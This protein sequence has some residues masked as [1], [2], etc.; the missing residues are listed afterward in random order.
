MALCIRHLELV[1]RHESIF[2]FCMDLVELGEEFY[3]PRLTVEAVARLETECVALVDACTVRRDTVPDAR[4]VENIAG[5]I[6]HA[7]QLTPS[8]AATM[9]QDVLVRSV[10]ASR[11]TLFSSEAFCELI[12]QIPEFAA[13]ILRNVISD[14][15]W[16]EPVGHIIGVTRRHQP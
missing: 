6:H 11:H 10:Y 4:L 5:D 16:G 8:P 1:F 12:D 13:K 7:F 3:V 15:S 14:S 9:C 2:R